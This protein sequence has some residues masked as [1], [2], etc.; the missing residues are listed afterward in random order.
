MGRIVEKVWHEL[1]EHY[2]HVE[3][4][5]FVIMPDHVHGIGCVCGW[6]FGSGFGFRPDVGECDRWVSTGKRPVLKPAPTQEGARP[7]S[8]RFETGPYAGCPYAR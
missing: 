5:A 4:D 2:P 6:G 3:L 7:G 1:P 8:G